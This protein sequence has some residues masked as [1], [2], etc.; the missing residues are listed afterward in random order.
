M[1]A[2]ASA[3][4][5]PPASPDDPALVARRRRIASLWGA[6]AGVGGVLAAASAGLPWVALRAG[7]INVVR[8]GVDTGGDGL[9]TGG[10]GLLLIA[11]AAWGWRRPE[12]PPRRAVPCRDDR[13]HRGLRDHEHPGGR[14]DRLPT[15]DVRDR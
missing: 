10:L 5:I 15:G 8:T 11:L 3:D 14:L 7:E 13:T 9:I 6:L 1:S 12:G 4:P 2:P